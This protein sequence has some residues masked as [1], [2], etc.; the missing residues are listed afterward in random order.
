MTQK[1]AHGPES[2]PQMSPMDFVLA[3]PYTGKIETN[4][5]SLTVSLPNPVAFPRSDGRE[6]ISSRQLF[7]I[8]CTR[9]QSPEAFDALIN[10][11]MGSKIEIGGYWKSQSARVAGRDNR[12]WSRQLGTI[13]ATS[14]NVKQKLV[15]VEAETAA[16]V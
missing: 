5:I 8:E 14:A 9:D 16:N 7:N 10:A 11:D 15:D 6:P 13:V 2:C 3:T 4:I 1:N 12:S